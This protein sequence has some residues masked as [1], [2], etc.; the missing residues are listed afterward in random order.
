[1][2]IE[3]TFMIAAPRDA[4][5]AFLLNPQE[6]LYC[7]PGV[8]S[9][10]ETDDGRYQATLKAKV[11]PIRASFAGTVSIDGRDGPERITAS[12]EGRDRSSGSIAQVTLDARLDETEPNVTTITSSAD[13][14]LR[15]RLGGFGTGV[16]QSIAGEMIGQFAKC[17]EARVTGAD[18]DAVSPGEVNA[19]NLA[20]VAMRGVARGAAQKLGGIRRKEEAR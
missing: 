15:G 18:E 12:G 14:T 10:T 16:I 17:V 7:V 19:P 1:M 3:Q 6:M 4:V 11:G 20:A 2:T 13:V 9:V 8:E 5:A